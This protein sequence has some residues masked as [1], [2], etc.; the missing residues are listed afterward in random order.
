MCSTFSK[1]MFAAVPCLLNSVLSSLL[2]TRAFPFLLWLPGSVEASVNLKNTF[3]HLYSKRTRSP[4]SMS[5]TVKSDGFELVILST[6]TRCQPSA[7]WFKLQLWKERVLA[8][9]FGCLP[10]KGGAWPFSWNITRPH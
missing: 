10:W 9:H 3:I 7:K 8:P 1:T 6:K 5:S 2:Q 4:Y